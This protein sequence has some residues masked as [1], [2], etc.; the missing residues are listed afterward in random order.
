M[1][2]IQ[3]LALSVIAATTL[4]S[5]S[6]VASSEGT[7]PEETI[8][9]TATRTPVAKSAVPATIKIIDGD[10]LREQLAASESLSDVLGN[11]LPSFSP[12]RQ[13]L[14]NSGETLRGRKPLY[15]IDGVPQSNP[16]RDGA[17]SANTIDPMMIERVEVIL[18]ANAIQGMGASGG[19]INIV[20]RQA[21]QGT[22]HQVTSGFSVAPA[23]SGDTLS[24]DLGYLLSHGQDNWQ[25]VTGIRIKETGMYVDGNGELIGVDSTQGDTMD[26]KSHDVFAKVGYQFSDTQSL[27]FMLNHFNLASN[28]DYI[29]EAGDRANNIAAV[30][31]EGELEG[32]AAENEV[33]TVSINFHDQDWFSGD[34]K[35]QVFSQSF[36]ALYGGGRFATFQDPALGNNIYDQSRNDSNKIGSRITINWQKIANTGF[37]I[38]TGFDFLR[39]RTYQELAQ[40]QRKWVPSTD[41]EN[42][43][44]YIQT[45][46]QIGDWH[47]NAGL[48]YEHGELQVDDFTTLYAYN[49]T[50]VAGGSPSFNEM[51]SNVGVVYDFSSQW[52]GYVSLSEGFSMPDVGRVLRGIN[53]PGL[54]VDSFLD[55]QPVLTDNSEVG[56]EFRGE[57][58]QFSLSYFQS[59]SDLGSRLS[60]NAD[61]IYEVNREKTDIYGVEASLDIDLLTNSLLGFD[62]SDTEGK[63]DSN[64]D[65]KVDSKLDGR[66]I[67]PR[68]L[69]AFLTHRWSDQWQSRLQWNKF[70]NR[71]IY[72][73]SA[74]I[75]NFEGYST[76]DITTTLTTENI[77]Q[78]IFGIE[79]LADEDYFTYYA[80][81]AGNDAR[82]FK[83]RGQ[84]VRVNWQYQ[85]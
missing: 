55:L 9:I 31:I 40:T 22:Q 18:G 5:N 16:L 38:T 43:A 71:H 15:L 67:A 26:A 12:S 51:L 48:R 39:D 1:L 23:N 6:V 53:Q 7:N 45:R 13:K 24:Y 30:S 27:E 56:I 46:Y 17:R 81:T 44:P 84:T 80:Q 29:V 14:T 50:Q 85:W 20:T 41:F 70:Y 19:I 82:N 34:F 49:S 37:D 74:A 63:Y 78:F 66:N 54:A 35:W 62:Y 76:I 10:E 72:V 83:G 64:D 25:L 65:G 33:T 59:N 77:G 73:G 52:R 11:L 69:N 61:G 21:Q 2:R 79:N 47:L 8:V 58:A 68:R 28:G 42:W 75:N 3:T 32:D 57:V 36:S 4:A 60:A